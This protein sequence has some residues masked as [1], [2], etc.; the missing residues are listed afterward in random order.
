MGVCPVQCVKVE[1][2]ETEEGGTLF[3]TTNF[4]HV[5]CDSLGGGGGGGGARSLEGKRRR[6]SYNRDRRCDLAHRAKYGGE[7][8]GSHFLIFVVFFWG[9]LFFLQILLMS[10]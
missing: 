9:G 7:I 6:A 3:N 10:L 2:V 4:F 1:R 8:D 5:S